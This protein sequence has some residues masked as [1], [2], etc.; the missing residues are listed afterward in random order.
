MVFKGAAMRAATLSSVI[1][2][3][4]TLLLSVELRSEAARPGVEGGIPPEVVAEYV[5]AIIQANRTLYTTHVVERMQ[6]LGVAEAT[7]QWKKQGTL[8]LPA[9]MLLMAGEVEHLRRRLVRS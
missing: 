5:Y 1:V 9:Q 2:L 4:L 6:E 8:P 3:G 7:E